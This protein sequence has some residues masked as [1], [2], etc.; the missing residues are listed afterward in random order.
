MKIKR[1]STSDRVNQL[2]S[3]AEPTFGIEELTQTELTLALNW[4]SQNKEKETSY[5]YLA[6]YCKAKGVNA[7]AFQIEQQ[8]ATVGFVCRMLTRGAILDSRSMEWLANHL[9]QMSKLV[10]EEKEPKIPTAKPA[11]I[12]DRLKEKSHASIGILESAVDEFILSDFK[13]NP[14]T[15]QIMRD[16]D[17]KGAHGPNI[18]NF[19][20]KCRDEFREAIAKPD[21]PIAEGYRNYTLPQLKKMDALYDQIVSDTLTI[22]GDSIASKAPRKKKAK[23]PEKQVKSL[24]Y[25]QD[26]PDLKIM[27]IPPTRL[28]ASE[29]VWV[30]NRKNRM[31]TYYAADDAA[32]L[33]IK[34]CAVLNYSKSKSRSKKLRHPEEILPKILSGG[35]VFLKNVFDTLTTKDTAVTGRLHKEILLL[36][37][38]I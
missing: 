7:K 4:Y 14:D 20:K 17:V 26:D 27:S 18:V 33:G 37:V 38:T 3:K 30:Y 16:N 36:G 21:G 19:F 34:G 11:T 29:G 13:K 1:Q 8:V 12:Q 31:L 25:C 28:I 24:K 35:K 15:L 2:L 22:M 6:E 9:I 10:A 23:S 32:G 5:K